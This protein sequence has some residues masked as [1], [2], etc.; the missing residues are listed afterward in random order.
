MNHWSDRYIGK[1]W[2]AYASGP[3]SFDCWGLVHHV[4]QDVFKVSGI[5]RYLDVATND[6]LKFHDAVLLEVQSGHWRSIPTSR[7][8]AVVLMGRTR[9]FS[10]VGIVAQGVVLHCRE[11]VGV[12]RESLPALGVLGF[13]MLEFWVHDGLNCDS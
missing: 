3:D 5:A 1:P 10:H 13:R 2:E 4:L 9:V 6:P 8:G 11:G 7:P 12:C